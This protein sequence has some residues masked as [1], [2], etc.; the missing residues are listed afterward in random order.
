MALKKQKT[1]KE[2]SNTNR[3]RDVV[4]KPVGE[5]FLPDLSR[6]T[7]K[8]GTCREVE[9]HETGNEN[10]GILEEPEGESENTWELQLNSRGA[11]EIWACTS[12]R[13]E[14]RAQS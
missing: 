2:E 8:E 3:G 6:R 1:Q 10:A 12:L 14:P 9:K 5:M 13:D 7:R 11:L 4:S